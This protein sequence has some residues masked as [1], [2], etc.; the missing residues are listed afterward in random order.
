MMNKTCQTKT[1]EKQ[2]TAARCVI[3]ELTRENWEFRNLLQQVT[4]QQ[5]RNEKHERSAE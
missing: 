5:K 3:D 1:L 4:M 2:L